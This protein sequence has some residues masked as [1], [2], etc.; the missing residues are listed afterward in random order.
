MNNFMIKN[1][2]NLP[3]SSTL[4]NFNNMKNNLNIKNQNL[5]Q[6]YIISLEN[7]NNEYKIKINN[8]EK[9]IK[10]L[11]IQ[12]EEKEE[13]INEE[14]IKNDNL[15]K[16]IKNFKNLKNIPNFN[17]KIKELE[18]EIKLFK[19]Y[20]KFSEG[21]KLISIKIISGNN[22]INFKKICKNTQEFSKIESILYKEYPKY[23]ESENYFLVH[24]NK[25]NKHKSLKENKINNNDEI[26][27]EVINFD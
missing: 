20:Y 13:I 25:I 24:G 6:N 14:K 27:L 4:L 3:K 17:S 9:L 16:E 18:N 26:I 21:E 7:Q 23:I 19:S 11:Q 15:Q 10:E 1:N 22:D 8:L 12:L 2:Q 5:S